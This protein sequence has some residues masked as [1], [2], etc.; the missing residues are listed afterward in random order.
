MQNRAW[1][2]SRRADADRDPDAVDGTGRAFSH[3]HF[4][5]VPPRSGVKLQDDAFVVG[6]QVEPVLIG[7]RD[8][9][10][11]SLTQ[12]VHGHPLVRQH[13]VRTD[14]AQV[15]HGLGQAQAPG[16]AAP[17]PRSLPHP[18]TVAARRCDGTPRDD[19]VAVAIETLLR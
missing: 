12:V 1:P 16:G 2:A 8:P 7:L 14:V 3:Q 13:L 4:P 10:Q 6:D 17:G 9:V 5:P 15:D 18:R 11:R 19:Q